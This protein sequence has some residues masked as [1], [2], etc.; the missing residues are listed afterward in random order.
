WSAVALAAGL[1]TGGLVLIVLNWSTV[2]GTNKGLYGIV[3]VSAVAFLSVGSMIARRQP[4]NPI[5]WLFCVMALGFAGAPLAQE[6]AVRGLGIALGSL[7]AAD[8]VGYASGSLLSLGFTPIILVFLLFPNGRPLSPR[9]RV[10]VW[11]TCISFALNNLAGALE[12]NAYTGNADRFL[13]NGFKILNPLGVPALKGALTI[14]STVSGV[15]L[16]ACAFAGLAA[17]I[18]RLRR[19]EGVERQQVR[20]LAYT[21]AAAVLFVPFMPL[22]VALHH[23][24]FGFLFW[25]GVVAIPALGIPVASGIAILKYRL[26]DLDVVVKKTVVLGALV[27]VGTFVYLAVV[28]GIGAAIGQKSNAALTLAAAAIVAIVFQPLRVRARRLADRLVYGKRATPYEVLSEFSERMAASYST[29]DVLPRMAR[30]LSE[31]TGAQRAGVWLRVGSEARLTAAWP[32][33]DH[34]GMSTAAVPMDD[35]GHLPGGDRM[36]PVR[37]LGEVLGALTVA[38][39]PTE[40]LTPSQEKLVSDLASQAALVLR[41]VRLIEELRA[42]RQ[43]LVAAQDQERRRLERNLHDGAQQQLVALAV[44]L[45]LAQRLATSDAPQ[46]AELLG[47]LRVQASEALDDLRDLARGIY[48]P[49]LADQGLAG[50]LQAQAGKAPLPVEVQSDDL[51]RYPPE[52]EA[53]VYFCVLEALQNVAKYAR[54]SK[55]R[56]RLE[57]RGHD[58]AFEVVDDGNGF[59][60]E[61]TPM[62]S[63][64]QNMSDRLTALGGSL[65]VRS[66]PG[67][68]TSIAGAIP[69]AAVS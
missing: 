11:A 30:V 9:W 53:A 58:L 12:P 36:F 42:S 55:A 16:L 41:N 65:K 62:G 33:L 67:S 59:D 47:R 38:M 32:P 18:L 5:G 24:I 19:A 26:Y 17:V 6:Y 27:A 3:M 44:Q 2:D 61:R 51:G 13:K 39:P 28:V 22:S 69:A 50:A 29:E 64:L 20:W 25:F 7:P 31:G 10:V 54:A 40:P 57:I 35:L 46:V 52:A 48:P 15:T 56:V 43:R 37:H 1:L 49:L 8:W 63:G 60:P 14:A 4:R 66:Q 68:G 21:A 34:D 45:G 23:Q